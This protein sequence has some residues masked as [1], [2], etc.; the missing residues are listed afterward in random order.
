MN[1]NL[2]KELKKYDNDIQFHDNIT[3]LLKLCSIYPE[4]TDYIYVE[5]G[6][7]YKTYVKMYNMISLKYY[8]QSLAIKDG[9][10]DYNA[11]LTLFLENCIYCLKKD[12][13]KTAMDSVINNNG[14]KDFY[15]GMYKYIYNIDNFELNLKIFLKS[16]T[17]IYQSIPLKSFV[18]SDEKLDKRKTLE[19]YNLN[20]IIYKEND[21]LVLTSCDV[22]YFNLYGYYIL[23][24]F[25]RHN[26]NPNIILIID[27]IVNKNQTLLELQNLIDKYS[28]IK[29]IDLCFKHTNCENI[30][31]YSSTLRFCRAYHQCKNK[32]LVVDIDSVILKSFEDLF[33]DM[34]NYDIGSRILEH[35]YPWQKYTA[36]FCFFNNSTKSKDVLKDIFICLNNKMCF[37]EELMWIDQN[38]LEY[39][40]RTNLQYNL[41]I[42]NYFGIKDEYIISPTGSTEIKINI[43]K[44]KIVY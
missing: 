44:S 8:Q 26:N 2:V 27:I 41:T 37:S 43:L 11:K 7:L 25:K 13:A 6:N 15:M 19:E 14:I 21:F 1:Y 3:Q 36:G 20:E 35:M 23:E 9:K 40:I 39:G 32:C 28:N 17:T 16:E 42:K 12:R 4:Y 38:A 22:N 29:N 5:I 31:A 34:N 10:Y 30:K 24:S 33:T 18:F